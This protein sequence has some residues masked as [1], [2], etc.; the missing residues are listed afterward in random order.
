MSISILQ[1]LGGL[2]PAIVD[3]L[4]AN[5]AT[6]QGEWA[7]ANASATSAL[8][9]PPTLATR[10][11]IA[12]GDDQQLPA[13]AQSWLVVSTRLTASAPMASG[14]LTTHTYE[15]SLTAYTRRQVRRAPDPSSSSLDPDTT[16]QTS[17]VLAVQALASMAAQTSAAH[18]SIM[19]AARAEVMG[20]EAST[21]SCGS[22]VRTVVEV[23]PKVVTAMWGAPKQRPAP[24][25]LARA[26]WPCALRPRRLAPLGGLT[27]GEAQRARMD[28]AGAVVKMPPAPVAV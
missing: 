1:T 5:L 6:I 21:S 9:L 10:A 12:A 18:A 24:D 22:R 19:A 23:T 26:L 4:R 17:A 14:S 25:G 7:T 27:C 20:A 11:I 8:A 15:V 13:Q 28:Q 3:C 16:V 2:A